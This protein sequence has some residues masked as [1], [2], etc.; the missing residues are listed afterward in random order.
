MPYPDR[1][2]DG[3]DRNLS[4]DELD[5]QALKAFQMIKRGNSQREAAVT[6]GITVRTLQRRLDRAILSPLDLRVLKAIEHERLEDLTL[7]VHE[8][9]D[10]ATT[11]QDV[12]L[13]LQRAAQLSARRVQLLG[14]DKVAPGIDDD[15]PLALIPP[16][17]R[18]ALQLA[19]ERARQKEA[20]ALE[21]RDDVG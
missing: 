13:L 7:R 4:E 15:D 20:E 16:A 17:L 6:L 9:L 14:L 3:Q 19:E 11:V 10:Q 12:G 21:R 2:D 18:G 1:E 8:E 5:A